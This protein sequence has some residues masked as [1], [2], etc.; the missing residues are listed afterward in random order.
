MNTTATTVPTVTVSP[1]K[2]LTGETE[3]T[4]SLFAPTA[5]NPRALI[6]GGNA[7]TEEEAERA[8]EAAYGDF[9]AR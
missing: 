9:L 1:V 4:W 6:A 8:A 7:G 5:T 2:G 3:W